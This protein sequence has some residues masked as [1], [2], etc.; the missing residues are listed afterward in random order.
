MSQKSRRA[1]LKQYQ[2]IPISK[3]YEEQ[4]RIINQLIPLMID[5]LSE[6]E[7]DELWAQAVISVMSGKEN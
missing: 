2:A 4:A 6:D 1:L 5:R 3:E 7:F